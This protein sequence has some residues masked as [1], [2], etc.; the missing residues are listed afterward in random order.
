M[1]GTQ[2]KNINIINNKSLFKIVDELMIKRLDSLF[3]N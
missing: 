1:P 3:E 2:T